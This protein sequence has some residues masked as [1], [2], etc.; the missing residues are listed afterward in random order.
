MLFRSLLGGADTAKRYLTPATHADR[1]EVPQQRQYFDLTLLTTAQ[2]EGALLGGAD[3]ARHQQAAL[4]VDRR[5]VPQQRPYVS[6]PS[7][8]PTQTPT[9]PLTVAW[10]VGGHYW[11]LYNQAA[12]Y[13]DRREVPQQREYESD[14]SLLLT[15]L[16]EGPLLVDDGRHRQFSTRPR[17]AQQLAPYPVPAAAADDPLTLAAGVGGDIWRHYNIPATHVDRRAVPQ[18]PQR[19]TLYF[20]AGPGSPPL[21]LAWGVGGHYWHLYNHAAGLYVR[22]WQPH[23]PI[24]AYG[25]AEVFTGVFGEVHGPLPQLPGAAAPPGVVGIVGGIT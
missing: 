8:Y 15:A 25:L 17:W 2:L 12:M 1:R 20:D 10:G 5:E 24:W 21:T 22:A 6:D 18:Q 23:Q 14:P 9:D 19:E 11:L 16:L 4:Y 3:T 13:V 7:F